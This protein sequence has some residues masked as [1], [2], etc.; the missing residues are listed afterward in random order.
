MYGCGGET[1]MSMY[2]VK[3]SNPKCKKGKDGEAAEIYAYA[4]DKLGTIKPQYCSNFC[5]K[6]AIYDK[7][8][9]G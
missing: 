4:T 5:K 8:F 9:I 1:K 7:R 6:E 2:K 3:C